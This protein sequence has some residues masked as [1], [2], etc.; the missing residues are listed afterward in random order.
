MRVLFALY[1]AVVLSL[2]ACSPAPAAREPAVVLAAAADVADADLLERVRRFAQR[3][4]HVPVRVL[5]TPELAELPGFQALEKAVQPVRADGDVIF[6]LLTAVPGETQHL[7]V[8]PENELA[9]VNVPP[10][11]TEDRET[12]ARRIERQV[13]R[14][15]AFAVGLPPTPDPFCVTRSYRSLDDL[16]RMGRN[17][18]PPWQGRFAEEAAKRGLVRP[19]PSGDIKRPGPK[20]DAP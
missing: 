20:A 7:A 12:F 14:A 10:L 9:A 15:A 8:F 11:R 13:M 5:D 3:E 4:L 17:F 1:S 19:E 18:S 6:I 16:D 2:C